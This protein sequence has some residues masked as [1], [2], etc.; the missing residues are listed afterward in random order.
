[1]VYIHQYI[2]S[3]ESLLYYLIKAIY[4]RG[5]FRSPFQPQNINIMKNYL[6]FL[7]ILLCTACG[8]DS[9]KKLTTTID[10]LVS[11]TDSVVKFEPTNVYVIID[12]S[13]S[14]SQKYAIPKLSI[15]AIKDLAEHIS[16]NGGGHLFLNSVDKNADNNSIVHCKIPAYP[17]KPTLR[18]K[19]VG[20]Q[21][22][23]YQ[24]LQKA[25][26]K[27]LS[28]FERDSVKATS[29][30]T[31][32]VENQQNGWRVYLERA[33]SSRSASED[34]SDIIGVLNTSYRSLKPYS[35]SFVLAISDLEHDVP[36]IE[37]KLTEKPSTISLIRVNASDSGN[38]VTETDFETD[39]FENAI[40]FIFTKPKL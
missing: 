9:T 27:E 13:G 23:Q 20:E 31:Q 33:Y 6:L 7:I 36:N 29:E 17:M 21:S 40:D 15:V 2:R 3:Q 5:V 37:K 34:F 22:Y 11:E 38:K 25:Y 16:H 8:E 24:K 10:Q 4:Q 19:F 18:E 26:L 12:G 1:M 32:L 30:L 14:G 35:K 28:T 39:S